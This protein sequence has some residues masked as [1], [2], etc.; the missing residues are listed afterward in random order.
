MS[1]VNVTRKYGP[2]S[3]SLA[4]LGFRQKEKQTF[5]FFLII[6]TLTKQTNLFGLYYRRVWLWGGGH[7]IRQ[8]FCEWMNSPFH[9][10]VLRSS[11]K[12]WNNE[13]GLTQAITILTWVLN[14]QTVLKNYPEAS[15]IPNWPQKCKFFCPEPPKI[16]HVSFWDTYGVPWCYDGDWAQSYHLS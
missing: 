15:F 6:S 13:S 9:L 11:H 14:H 1:P 12:L 5:K 4:N 3:S 2:L 16:G 8:F 7:Y 10:K